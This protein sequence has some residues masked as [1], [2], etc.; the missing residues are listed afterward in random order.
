[1]PKSTEKRD[2]ELAALLAEVRSLKQD[3]DAL[4]RSPVLGD[5]IRSALAHARDV[6]REYPPDYAVLVRPAEYPPDYAVL[7]RPAEYPPD[8]AVLVRPQLNRDDVVLPAARSKKTQSKKT[9]S[10]KT[11]SKK[12]QVVAEPSASAR[13]AVAPRKKAKSRKSGE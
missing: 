8:Y 9:Q 4:K 13:K 10:K 6:G 3:F 11:Q 1:M 7:V 2:A 5:A 12:T